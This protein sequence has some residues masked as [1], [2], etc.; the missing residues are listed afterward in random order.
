MRKAACEPPV[1]SVFVCRMSKFLFES[2]YISL[3]PSDGEA[4]DIWV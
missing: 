1:N 3:V 4:K 2:S